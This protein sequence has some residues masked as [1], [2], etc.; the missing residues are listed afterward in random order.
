MNPNTKVIGIDPA[1]V[2][3]STV[4]DGETIR[5]LSFENLQ[6]EVDS[7]RTNYSELLICW[8]APL[9][10]TTGIKAPYFKMIE[11]KLKQV[12]YESGNKKKPGAEGVS[13]LPFAGCPHW[14]ISRYVL[15]LPRFSKYDAANIPFKL[16][17]EKSELAKISFGVVETHPAVAL[18]YWSN[19]KLGAYKGSKQSVISNIWQQVLKHPHVGMLNINNRVLPKN[20]DE[21]DAIAAYMLGKLWLQHENVAQ[22]YG[23][24]EVGAMLL[25]KH[26]ELDNVFYKS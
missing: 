21:L 19:K 4:F 26:K 8:D 25:P 1:P 10:D 5:H 9:L 23:N 24:S 3:E 12:F 11:S 18:Y 20:D 13:V 16:I 7:Y 22:L 15:G 17:E 14:T 6:K 2:K